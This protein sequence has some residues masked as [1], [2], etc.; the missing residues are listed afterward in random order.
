M[1]ICDDG[2]IG[3]IGAAVSVSVASCGGGDDKVE[4]SVGAVGVVVKVGG[5]GVS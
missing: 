5:T 3:V 4:D 1:L 2:G